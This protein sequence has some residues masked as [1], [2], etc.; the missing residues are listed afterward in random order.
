MH[1]WPL[2]IFVASAIAALAACGAEPP[3]T[4][5]G[6]Q[7]LSLEALRDPESCRSCH[8]EHYLEWQSSM[9]AYAAE[10]PVFIAMN[11]RGQLET[12][13]ALGDFCVK[14]HAPMAL[15]LGL[16]TDG[17]NL[18]DLSD[19][20]ARGV[21]CYFCHSISS[22]DGDHNRALS[23][24]HD[25]VLRGG[26]G[27]GAGDPRNAAPAAHNAAHRSRYSSLH[28]ATRLE[29]AGL[30][31]A[32][33]D[34]VT[35]T[36]VEL[37]RTFAEWKSSRFAAGSEAQTCGQCHMERRTGRAAEGSAER[38]LHRHLWPGVDVALETD[39]PGVQ[40]QQAAIACA[41]EAALELTLTATSPSFDAFQVTL[42][43]HRVGHAWPSGAA[44]DRRAWV[45]FVAYDERGDVLY[46]RGMVEPGEVVGAREPE[47]E[48]LRDRLFDAAGEEVHMF[49]QAAPSPQHPLGYESTLLPPPG[50]DADAAVRRFDYALP[51]QAAR[52]TARLRLQ[53]IGLDVLDSFQGIHL[54]ISERVITS[55]YRTAA[56]LRARVPTI[57]VPG[58][59]RELR[60]APDGSVSA[61]TPAPERSEACKNQDYASLLVK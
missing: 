51:R 35:D 32:C 49:W 33:H 9:H 42:T 39:F 12:D 29:S 46:Q 10:D 1:A 36:G 44:Q 45:E 50:E 55:S 61:D 3:S 34:I 22:V 60:L 52:V 18:P 57:T 27:A 15:E 21:T 14:C 6:E 31:G 38:T 24:S 23:L 56:T 25:G 8:L 58:S 19:P 47:L 41:F 2:P 30:C 16:T 4:A 20:S 59:E 53:S 40:A 37:E 43:N 11:E 54:P 13:G 48:I 5:I 7:G 17:T 28:D 26:L